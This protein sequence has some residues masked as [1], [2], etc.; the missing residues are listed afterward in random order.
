MQYAGKFKKLLGVGTVS[1]VITSSFR[2]V[3]SL[4]GMMFQD[5]RARVIGSRVSNALLAVHQQREKLW[6][7]FQSQYPTSWPRNHMGP[8][9][10]LVCNL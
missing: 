5:R 2:S 3:P 4:E 10:M 8:Q 1:S 6:A 7:P 9:I